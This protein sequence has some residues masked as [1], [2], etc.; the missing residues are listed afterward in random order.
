M[1]AVC[2]AEVEAA[3]EQEQD[4]P[5]TLKLASQESGYSVDHL[6]RMIRDGMI[7]NAGR[8]GS[9]R[10]LRRN[11]PVQNSRLRELSTPTQYAPADIRQ[12]ARSIVTSN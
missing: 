9:P 10:I 1:L 8:K 6:G 4:E 3:L 7:S 5:L 12:T 2:V 11:L